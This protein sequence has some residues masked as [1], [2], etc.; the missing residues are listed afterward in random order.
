MRES[1]LRPLSQVNHWD[2]SI[3]PISI[4]WR[5]HQSQELS[6]H[7][8]FSFF[9]FFLVVGFLF[10]I[11]TAHNLTCSEEAGKVVLALRVPQSQHLA[12]RP[13]I[14]FVETLVVPRGIL[15]GCQKWGVIWDVFLRRATRQQRARPARQRKRKGPRVIRWGLCNRCHSKSYCSSVTFISPLFPVSTAP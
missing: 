2:W 8:L 4:T 9:F 7:I 13:L 15:K 10:I 14:V 3:F 5:N 1:P 11:I 6:A 12:D